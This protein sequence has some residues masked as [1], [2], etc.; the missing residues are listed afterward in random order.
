MQ[1]DNE[2]T[3]NERTTH[4]IEYWKQITLVQQHFNDISMK[5]RNFAI[6]IFSGFLT[7]VGL[8][9]HKGVFVE[10]FG[11]KFSAGIIFALAGAFVTQLI[12]FMD[13]YWYHVFLKG[14]VD[15]SIKVEKEINEILKIE[16]LADDISSQ[17]QNVKVLS[18]FG[19]IH[20]PIGAQREA[21]GIYFKLRKIFFKEIKV[22]STLRHK[23]FY[24]W[25]ILIIAATGIGSLFA[26]SPQVS[27]KDLIE[28][29]PNKEI[30]KAGPVEKDFRNVKELKGVMEE[31]VRRHV[32]SA[33]N[34]RLRS[35][36]EKSSPI[37]DVLPAGKV[38]KIIDDS[39]S[40][41]IRIESTINKQL[42]NGW[43]YREY[44]S[45]LRE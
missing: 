22:D 13:T 7:G 32:I 30:S 31:A 19:L 39:N 36:P 23:I 15:T 12:H 17:S 24:R 16:K 21:D 2:L 37:I 8:S 11:F 38:V 41:W 4:L 25:L 43:V 14:A 3:K 9:I 1:A 26:T 29:I 33:S 34:V 42:I 35:A 27:N 10:V 18:L 45:Q 40:S 6:V 28:I 20:L 44:I 5:V